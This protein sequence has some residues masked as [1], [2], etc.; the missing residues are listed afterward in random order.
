MPTAVAVTTSHP[1]SVMLTLHL[2][3]KIGISI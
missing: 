1:F 2:S 3:L